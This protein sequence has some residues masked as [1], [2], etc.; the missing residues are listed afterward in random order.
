MET[1]NF[2]EYYLASK[3][4]NET[5]FNFE[6][7]QSYSEET[8]DKQNLESAIEYGKNSLKLDLAFVI[9]FGLGIGGL[10]EPLQRFYAGQGI[11]FSEQELILLAG[12][13]LGTLTKEDFVNSK[14][15]IDK[16]LKGKNKLKKLASASLQVFRGLMKKIQGQQMLVTYSFVLVPIMEAINKIS[17]GNMSSVDA[18]TIKNIAL[19][20]AINFSIYA[21]SSKLKTVFNS[22]KNKFSSRK[23]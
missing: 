7:N 15:A 23:Q 4:V 14:K 19:G 1:Y 16:I 20:M 3:I 13:L 6:K 11:T 12:S 5:F 17:N 21:G 9:K 8:I 18:T 10:Y 2:K 22:L